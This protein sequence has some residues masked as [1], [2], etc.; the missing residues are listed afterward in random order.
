MAWGGCLWPKA[1]G[2]DFVVWWKVNHYYPT[3][4][5]C[6]NIKL[7]WLQQLQSISS[8]LWWCDVLLRW[9][10]RKERS[11]RGNPFSSNLLGKKLWTT[12]N[13][14]GSFKKPKSSNRW[15]LGTSKKKH[16]KKNHPKNKKNKKHS[17]NNQKHPEN[18]KKTPNKKKNIS[19]TYWGASLTSLLA[20]LL[21]ALQRLPPWICLRS[22]KKIKNNSKIKK[23]NPKII[24]K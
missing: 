18:T 9:L 6:T 1:N 3:N 24:P 15:L 13:N 5:V 2:N 17:K 21:Q 4:V 7:T 23:K 22:P 14:L 16:N 8:P 20:R 11:K 10:G 19:L 12:S